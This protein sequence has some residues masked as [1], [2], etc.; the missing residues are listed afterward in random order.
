MHSNIFSDFFC[1]SFYLCISLQI[2]ATELISVEPNV[3]SVPAPCTIVGDIHGQY[4]DLIEMFK[5]GGKSPDINYVFLGDYVDRGCASVETVSLLVCLKVRYPSRVTLLRGN[6]ESRQ[7]TQVFR[8]CLCVFC[9]CSPFSNCRYGFYD[10]CFKK[11]GSATVWNMFTDL[12]D[13]IP[14]GALIQNSV[15]IDL[16]SSVSLFFEDSLHSWWFISCYYNSG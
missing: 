14:L 8:C 11:Y 10:E 16:I 9:N 5:I 12:F 13:Y 6:H 1:V 4:P 7:I 15:C 2:Q 3:I